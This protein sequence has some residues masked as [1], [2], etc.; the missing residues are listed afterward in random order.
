MKK[1]EHKSSDAGR[2][3]KDREKDALTNKHQTSFFFF[4]II[5]PRVH[6][7]S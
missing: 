7:V 1:I 5:L 4:L 3:M 6:D 2:K